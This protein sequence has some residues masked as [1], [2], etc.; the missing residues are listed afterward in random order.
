[1]LTGEKKLKRFQFFKKMYSVTPTGG[2]II[3]SL[4]VRY[5]LG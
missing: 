5:L 4:F 1:M 2:I 3:T